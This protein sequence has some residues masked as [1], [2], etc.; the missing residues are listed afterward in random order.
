MSDTSEDN[1]VAWTEEKNIKRKE[2]E[3][4]KSQVDVTTFIWNDRIKG[5]GYKRGICKVKDHFS[6]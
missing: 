3:R 1:T 2:N 6:L 5:L 4:K